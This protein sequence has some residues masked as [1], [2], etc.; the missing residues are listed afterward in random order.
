MQV[1]KEFVVLF[2][3][4]QLNWML[5]VCK[6]SVMA[7]RQVGK[8]AAQEEG[9]L[10]WCAVVEGEEVVFLEGNNHQLFQKSIAHHEL[11]AGS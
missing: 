5:V 7:I 1:A 2:I 9:L 10:N 3:S 11:L 8:V 6:Q 4:S